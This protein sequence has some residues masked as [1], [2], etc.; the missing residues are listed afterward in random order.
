[1]MKMRILLV[2]AGAVGQVYGRHLAAAGHAVS[3]FV[4][5]AH[6]AALASGMPLHRLGHVRTHSEVWTDYALVA[7]LHVV[8]AQSWD[9]IWLCTSSDALRTPLMRELLARVGNATLV[10]L[11]PGP[12]DAALVREQLP[13]PAQLVQGLITFIS[14]QSPLPGASGPTGI[15]FYLPPMAPALFS[16]DAPRVHAVVQ[17][18]KEGGMT[19]RIVADLHAASGGADGLLIPLVA[20]L[21]LHD[22]KLSALAGSEAFAL[23]SDAARETLDILAR[24]QGARVGMTKLVL[25]P[26]LSRSALLLAPRFLPLPL[27]TY[28]QYHFSKVG[29]QTRQ[30]LDSYAALGE[31]H[32]LPVVRLRE[33]RRRLS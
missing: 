9:Q 14:Y 24:E 32:G 5:P 7:E 13:D 29:V 11:Q 28:L 6:V 33:L 3:F 1:M 17:A 22:W 15:S 19:A 25:H 12:E 16:G 23:G 27:Q 26:L 21:E 8:A 4:K 31:R 2:G 18:L 30:M 20:A 10:C